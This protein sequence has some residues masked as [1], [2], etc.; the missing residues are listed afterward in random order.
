MVK[1][2]VFLTTI[3]FIVVLLLFAVLI[4]FI[5]YAVIAPYFKLTLFTVGTINSQVEKVATETLKKVAANTTI[6]SRL[7]N[8]TNATTQFESNLGQSIA[9]S[10]AIWIATPVVSF[11]LGV[12]IYYSVTQKQR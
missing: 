7:L 2:G 10:E 3:T 5:Y 9:N 6:Y 4:G 1:K 12:L 8:A 11:L